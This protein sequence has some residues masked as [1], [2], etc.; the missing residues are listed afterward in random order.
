[1]RKVSKVSCENSKKCLILAYSQQNFKNPALI[2]A[3][4]DEKYK[5][6][7]N[8]EKILK[9]FDINSLEKLNFYLCLEKL[10][11]KIEPSEITSFFYNN[12]FNFGGGGNVPP[13]GATALLYK[14]AQ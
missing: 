8:F 14:L 2:F 4:L 1:M 9:F 6:L 5:V 10:L 7:G 12:F 3:R 13:G 11:L